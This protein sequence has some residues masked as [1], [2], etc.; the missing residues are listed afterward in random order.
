MKKTHKSVISNT[1]QISN[2]ELQKCAAWVTSISA[3]ELD[4]KI[5]SGIQLQKSLGKSDYECAK[6]IHRNY[7]DELSEIIAFNQEMGIDFE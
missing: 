6:Y 1:V 2:K 3:D 7:K 5:L 4:G